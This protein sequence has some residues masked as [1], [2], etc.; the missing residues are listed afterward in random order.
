MPDIWGGRR[1]LCCYH[2]LRKLNNFILTINEH[3]IHLRL[4]MIV[5]LFIYHK[6]AVCRLVACSSFES[7]SLTIDCLCQRMPNKGHE[8][9]SVENACS[10][11]HVVLGEQAA[12]H[13]Y[14][15]IQHVLLHGSVTKRKR[16]FF[17]AQL[18]LIITMFRFTLK[19]LRQ[20]KTEKT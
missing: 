11:K 4:C 5:K 8:D 9:S 18:I 14:I 2:A 1:I 15:A 3:P 20:F 10:L 6:F 7:E 12:T 16:S 13:M 17:C 19:L